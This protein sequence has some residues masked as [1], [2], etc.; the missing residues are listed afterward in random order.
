MKTTLGK[1]FGGF[2][3]LEGIILLALPVAVFGSNFNKIYSEAERKNR[4]LEQDKIEKQRL[5]RAIKPTDD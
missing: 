4:M 2:T 3:L 1:I 5:K